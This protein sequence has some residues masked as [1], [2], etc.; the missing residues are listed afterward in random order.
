MIKNS[1]IAAPDILQDN[2]FLYNIYLIS[3][4]DTVSDGAMEYFWCGA[5]LK[6]Q[7]VTKN[8]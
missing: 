1:V 5:G 6:T 7:N 8:S 3:I 4:S 2:L